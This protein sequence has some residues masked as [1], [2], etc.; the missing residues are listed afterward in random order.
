MRSNKRFDRLPT[1]PLPNGFEKP[2]DGEPLEPIVVY[3]LSPEEMDQEMQRLG[4][5]QRPKSSQKK[6]IDGVIL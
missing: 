6:T 1:R 5:I 2:R 4:V 3:Q